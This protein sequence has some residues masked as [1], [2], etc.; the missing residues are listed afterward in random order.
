MRRMASSWAIS[1]NISPL[2]I[3]WKAQGGFPGLKLHFYPRLNFWGDVVNK[4]CRLQKLFTSWG[5][6]EWGFMSPTFS[7][8]SLAMPCLQNANYFHQPWHRKKFPFLQNAA[9]FS[10]TGHTTTCPFA[11]KCSCRFQELHL[12]RNA[13]ATK[14]HVG[15]YKTCIQQNHPKSIKHHHRSFLLFFNSKIWTRLFSYKMSVWF[16]WV[17]LK[18]T[19][20]SYKMPLRFLWRLYL[21]SIISLYNRIHKHKLQNE[22]PGF[23]VTG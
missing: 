17:L 11:T 5:A 21:F 14:C 15:F 13:F 4:L 7:Q 1:W 18:L 6:T 23:Y 2:T 10:T 12:Q 9:S 19:L 3:G 20:A 8:H 22:G 16:Q